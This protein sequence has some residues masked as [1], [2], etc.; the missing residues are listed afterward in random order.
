MKI[1]ILNLITAVLLGLNAPVKLKKPIL[2]ESVKY[3]WTIG[4]LCPGSTNSYSWICG[5]KSNADVC[6]KGDVI[7]CG[8]SSE[9]GFE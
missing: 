4:K 6:R 1:F 8:I 9:P 2:E 7:N 5:R 3:T